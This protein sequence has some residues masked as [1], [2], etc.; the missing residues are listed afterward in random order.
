MVAISTAARGFIV[1]T[2][3]RPQI[4][5]VLYTHA[6]NSVEL[7]NSGLLLLALG[8]HVSYLWYP[9]LQMKYRIAK[10][11]AMVMIITALSSIRAVAVNVTALLTSILKVK[12]MAGGSNFNYQAWY[13]TVLFERMLLTVD[14][15]VEEATRLV[16]K[17]K[18]ED[19][20]KGGE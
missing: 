11:A 20:R 15:N 12:Y 13:W 2:L 16:K 3:N 5:S 19:S 14:G 4:S 6:E 7:Y 10:L 9:A 1:E 18:S 17:R 8:T